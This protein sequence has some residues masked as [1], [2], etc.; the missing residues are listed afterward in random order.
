MSCWLFRIIQTWFFL[1]FLIYS[2][3]PYISFSL[4]E[5][6]MEAVSF[7][8]L[9]E[10]V[11]SLFSLLHLDINPQ[12]HVWLYRWG[13]LYLF[14]FFS[15]LSSDINLILYLYI[16]HVAFLWYY[17]RAMTPVTLKMRS[18]RLHSDFILIGIS[19]TVQLN[20][21]LIIKLYIWV[22][23]YVQRRPVKIHRR[24]ISS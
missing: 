5:K 17:Q 13:V 20:Q 11:P 1:I 22:C 14:G 12:I 2:F 16:P 4:E 3:F 9:I 15:L 7:F 23:L 6:K 24:W 19:Y 21:S 10:K 18:S 8:F